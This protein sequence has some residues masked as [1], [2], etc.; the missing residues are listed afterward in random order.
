[1]VGGIKTAMRIKTICLNIFI[2]SPLLFSRYFNSKAKNTKKYPSLLGSISK[3]FL[4]ARVIILFCYKVNKFYL[5][6]SIYYPA[7]RINGPEAL[8]RKRFLMGGLS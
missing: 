6:K 8:L 4:E 3:T 5:I 2:T 1:M 7:G